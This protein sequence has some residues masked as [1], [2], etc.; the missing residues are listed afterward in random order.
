MNLPQKLSRIVLD[1]KWQVI[2]YIIKIQTLC[3]TMTITVFFVYS[4]KN[5]FLNIK[6]ANKAG[7]ELW[8]CHFGSSFQK[9]Y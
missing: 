8:K 4:F 1:L 5:G 9:Q 7:E 3:A 2:K 6:K